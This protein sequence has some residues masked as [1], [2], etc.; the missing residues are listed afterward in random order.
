MIPLLKGFTRGH[1]YVKIRVSLKKIKNNK[2]GGFILEKI[3]EQ[4]TKTTYYSMVD[5]KGSIPR[6]ISNFASKSQAMTVV[7]MRKRLDGK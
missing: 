7:E 6:F 1:C 4:S 5:P 3:D 2:V